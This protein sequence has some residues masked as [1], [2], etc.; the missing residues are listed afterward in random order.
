MAIE[1][2]QLALAYRALNVLGFKVWFLEWA[3]S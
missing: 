3:W 2:K 1:N